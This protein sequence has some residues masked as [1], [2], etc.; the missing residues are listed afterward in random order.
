M[1]QIR[2]LSFPVL[3]C[4]IITFTTPETNFLGLACINGGAFVCGRE[5]KYRDISE[6]SCMHDW[7]WDGFGKADEMPASL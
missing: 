7:S 1:L 6:A 4:Q 5:P 2:T 3:F